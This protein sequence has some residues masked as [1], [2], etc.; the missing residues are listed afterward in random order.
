MA[1]FRCG[2][3]AGK[4]IPDTDSFIDFNG[5]IKSYTVGTAASTTSMT[6][7]SACYNS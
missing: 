3:G 4:A 1:L 7:G 5:T 6:G 2:A